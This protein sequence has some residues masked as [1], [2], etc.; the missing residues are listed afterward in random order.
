M[1]F[2][3]GVRWWQPLS[4]L[5]VALLIAAVTL[6]SAAHPGPAAA[7]DAQEQ[8][9]LGLINHYRAANGLGPLSL[10]DQLN[11]DAIWMSQDMAG[12]NYFS[13][14]DSLGRDPFQRM[15]DFGYTYNTWRGENLAAG[16]ET[17]QA[18]LDLFKGSPEHNSIMLHRNFKVIGIAR[19]FAP[20]TTYGWYWTTEFGGQG[21]P[22]PPAQPP[23]P[24]ETVAPPP[25]QATP[26]EPAPQPA[27]QPVPEATSATSPNPTTTPPAAPQPPAELRETPVR[28]PTWREIAAVA[29]PA[30]QRLMVLDTKGELLKA[31]SRTAERYLAFTTGAFVQET[32]PLPQITLG[33]P[34]PGQL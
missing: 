14:T 11:Q 12:Q 27:P 31:L 32:L 28:L 24:A 26:A 23:A 13:H 34:F 19:A 25:P 20:G 10:N 8:A 15:A 21:E 4:A 33:M 17:A 16:V 18:A 9:F 5:L 7:L 6:G 22:L 2:G 3:G 30:W 1:G 29:R